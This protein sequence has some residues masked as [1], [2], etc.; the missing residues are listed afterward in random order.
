M[1][2]VH[3]KDME[4]LR[5]LAEDSRKSYRE[6]ARKLGI[7]TSTVMNRVNVMKKEGV[8][9][10]STLHLDHEKLGYSL[11]A[12]IEITV[13][14]GKMIEIEN[15]IAKNP[16]VYAVYDITGEMDAAILARFKNRKEL[17]GFVKSLLATEF[18]ERTNTHLVLNVIKE[19]YSMF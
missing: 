11:T 3:K 18:I 17:N 10:S 15:K 16:N 1:F 8:I 7:A 13:A 12:L 14:K 6:I 9:K 19:E 5:E 4:I 2:E